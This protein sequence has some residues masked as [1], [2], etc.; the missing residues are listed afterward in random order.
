M[1]EQKESC[2]CEATKSQILQTALQNFDQLPNA[3]HVRERVV[4]AVL[5]CS[6][7]TV[8]RWSKSG[9][10]PQPIRLSPRVS[11]WNVGQLRQT[12]SLIDGSRKD[13]I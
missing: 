8:W 7:A 5:G 13:A 1:S 10:I 4:A 6:R 9:R 3:A 12:L 11:A 2:Q